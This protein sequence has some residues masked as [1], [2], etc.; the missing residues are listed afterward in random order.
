MTWF[1]CTA[2]KVIFGLF[3]RR[4]LRVHHEF[5]ESWKKKPN[6]TVASPLLTVTRWPPSIKTAL[7]PQPPRSLNPEIALRRCQNSRSSE[8]PPNSSTTPSST[9]TWATAPRRPRRPNPIRK[10][11]ACRWSRPTEA[12]FTSRRPAETRPFWNSSSQ[13]KSRTPKRTAA[14]VSHSS[15]VL[16][17]VWLDGHDDGGRPLVDPPIL[18]AAELPVTYSSPMDVFRW[19]N[20]GGRPRAWYYSPMM[21]VGKT[22]SRIGRK[23]CTASFRL[24][25]HAEMQLTSKENKGLFCGCTSWGIVCTDRYRAVAR[26]AEEL[27]SV[28][29]LLPVMIYCTVCERQQSPKVLCTVFIHI[30]A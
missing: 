24:T 29:V 12:R 23:C 1:T 26:L 22:G 19:R 16:K 25:I 27:L 5:L 4:S 6:T 7:L 13:S 9:V 30:C 2:K 28:S 18:P 21:K 11:R 10:I 14:V 3:Y 17:R 8:R 20:A 15:H